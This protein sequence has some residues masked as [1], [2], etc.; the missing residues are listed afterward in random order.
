M[1]ISDKMTRRGAMAG[2]VAGVAALGL[3]GQAV[4]LNAKGAKALVDAV[5]ADI[6]AVI[7]SGKPEMQMYEDFEQIFADYAD[8]PTMARYALGVEAR[9]A[10]KKQLSDFTGAFQTY[11]ATKYGKRFREFIGGRVEVKGAREVKTFFEVDTI[12]HLQG[13]APF[14]VTFQV[15]DRSG[16]DLFFNLFIEGLNMLLAERSEIGAMLDQ[17]GGDLDKLIADLQAG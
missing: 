13:V 7:S 9:S 16:K 12:A 3:P 17:R 15:S 4:A 6:N 10:S 1:V 11:I 14:E 5:V 2:L 8:V